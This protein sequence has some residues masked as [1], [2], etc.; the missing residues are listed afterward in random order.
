MNQPS[1]PPQA[2]EPSAQAQARI[3]ELIARMTLDEKI[4]QMVQVDTTWK[5]DL[6]R[7]IREG[8][9]GSL[10]SIRGPRKINAFQ[11]IAVEESRL[12]IP[13]VVGNDVIHGYRTIFPIP[14]G[15]ACSWDT[16]LIER[17][18]R[19]SAEEAVAAG[20]HWNFAPMVDVSRD[21]RWGRV[22]EGPGEDAFLGAE[23]A[24]AWVRGFQAENL[25]GGRRLAACVKHYGAYGGVEGGKDYN[26]VD[27][28]ERR[29]RGEYLPPYR[30]A[31]QAGAASVMT[32]FTE[33]NGVPATA[34][35]HLLQD[36]L[37][38]EWGFA[39]VILSDYDAI[40]EL[41]Y[42]G[43]AADH[44]DAA[45][46]SALAGV[47]MDMMGNA[48]PFH[49]ADLV[50]GGQISEEQVDA[51]VRRVLALKFQLGL[52]EQ[53]YADEAL[54]ERAL[55][56]PARLELAREAAVD[57]I[58]LLKNEGDLLPLDV[59][60]K[61]VALIGPLATER[62]GLL[63]SWACEGRA[64]ETPS[65][66]ESLRAALPP[67]ARL[68]HAQGC[69][70]DGPAADLSAALQA[71][72]QA[73]VVVLA[74]G[75]ADTMS[76]EAHSRAHLGLP[77]RQQELAES[78]LAAGAPLVAVLISGRPLAAPWLAQNAAAVVMAW[79]G[80]SRAGEAL[81]DV[82]LGKA[83]PGGKLTLSVPRSEGQ[84]PVYYAHKR[85]GRPA[86]IAGITQFNQAHRSVYLDEANAPLYPFGYGLSYSAFHYS[87]L[88]VEMPEIKTD[89][90]LGV[91]AEVHNTSRRDGREI[92]QC[93]VRDLVGSVTRPVKELKGFQKVF[94]EAGERRRVRFEI[95]A[96]AL[97]FYDQDMRFGVEPGEFKVW[98][99]PNSQE[100]LEGSFRVEG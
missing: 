64:E 85:T 89:G 76:G 6:P 60:G 49:L 55:F 56:Q 92:V 53:P 13:L 19:A 57:S 47:D 100:G 48:Y 20:T 35:R 96:S 43:L 36:I 9:I 70:L 74:V 93:Y 16:A 99:G 22:A 17:V 69:E 18:A 58:V 27:M 51:S 3:Q 73:D 83:N 46:Q 38:E 50:R 54:S 52:F 2:F 94:L 87:D 23:I 78:L 41:I 65:L 68:L 77:G 21:P 84:I 95:A 15:L 45:L 24:G 61:T 71:A 5:Q 37:R 25:P 32:A 4:G 86:D 82:L 11:K 91:S 10:L 81:A 63:G 7:L 33:L 67:D 90:S 12:G 44:R 1:Q 88:V 26:T 29:L 97:G 42:H 59:A 79:Q 39:G 40:G 30:A 8:K 34:N 31:L 14:L 28:S 80:G 98:I 72:R 75:E 62:R 66:L